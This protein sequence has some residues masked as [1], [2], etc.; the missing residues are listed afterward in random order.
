MDKNPFGLCSSGRLL[1]IYI[2]VTLIPKFFI[3]FFWKLSFKNL[4]KKYTFYS[5]SVKIQVRPQQDACD[6]DYRFY[7]L[8]QRIKKTKI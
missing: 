7:Q 5:Q 3:G 1:Q 8:T 2:G 6:V 4:K